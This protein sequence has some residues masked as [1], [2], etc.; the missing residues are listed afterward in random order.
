MSKTIELNIP[1]GFQLEDKI[2][3]MKVWEAEQTLLSRKIKRY[4]KAVRIGENAELHSRWLTCPHC[5]SRYIA[6]AN[7]PAFIQRT[8]SGIPA[9]RLT[10]EQIADWATLQM[11]IFDSSEKKEL[12]IAP[13]ITSLSK[14]CCANCENESYK[15]ASVRRVTLCTGGKKLTVKC[16]VTQLD[17]ILSLGW[18][19]VDGIRISFPL[20]EVLTFDLNRG[21]VYIKMENA[22]GEILCRRDITQCPERLKGGAAY[23]LLTQNKL[24]Q[25]NV[26]RLFQTLWETALPF[27]GRQ[28]ELQSLFQMTMFVGYPRRF[29]DSIPY[30]QY[31]F[32]IDK[33]FRSRAKRMHRAERLDTIYRNSA[34]PQVKSLRR[35]L[36]ADPGLFFYLP[37]V[38]QVWATIG[39]PNFMARFLQNSRVYEVL[40]SIHLRPGITLFIRDFCKVRGTATLL[41]H[42][43][44]DWRFLL[45]KA[46]DYCCMSERLRLQTQ[47][48]WRDKEPQESQ[49]NAYS[50][51][52]CSPD[53]TIGDCVIDGYAFVW[54]RN[55]ND[56][57][58]AALQLKNCLAEWRHNDSPVV[59]IRRKNRFV[60][61][62]EVRAHQVVQARTYDN[63]SVSANP[64]LDAV[65]QKWMA[66][67]HLKWFQAEADDDD[68]IIPLP[69]NLPMPF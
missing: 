54:L 59:G 39:D 19:K 10:K 65:L 45:S 53:E 8:A 51:P 47:Q 14:F 28:L 68:L 40:S 62:V 63:G 58:L 49:G 46:I 25:R 6:N 57:A 17:E 42:L 22:Q 48:K 9:L 1:L 23:K 69:D 43:Q 30:G 27:G 26:K 20:F 56:Y 41:D 29:Y 5:G 32:G 31:S 36:F 44:S 15:S 38:E 16:E 21:A 33:D 11:S 35:S 61:A 60:A 67:Y 2:E 37:E 34:L 66:R 24:V 7:A 64:A 12:L 55:S 18:A 4:T 3:Y 50:I 52:M 13:P